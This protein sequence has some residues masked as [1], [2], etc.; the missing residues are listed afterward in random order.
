MQTKEYEIIRKLSKKNRILI[1]LNSLLITSCAILLF[2]I[3]CQ[4]A[5]VKPYIFYTVQ[6]GDTVSSISRISGLSIAEIRQA[7][8]FK[9]DMIYIGDVL[10]LP[11]IS[12]LKN[13]Q[14]LQ[15]LPIITRNEWGA[16][17]AGVCDKATSFK[18]ITVHHTTDNDK[19]VKT[20]IEFL[21]LVQKHHQKTNKWADIGYHFLIGQGGNL[22]EGRNLKFTGAHVRGKNAGNIGIALL[23]DY[24]EHELKPKQ[25]ETLRKL[26]D[27][28]RE[29]YN[30]PKRMIFG[31]GELGE[32]KCP[33]KHTLKFLS[34]YRK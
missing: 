5:E 15:E 28:L 2:L 18:R 6:S 13:G 1:M 8:D 34:N 22:Y 7:N 30:I 19:F 12:K 27:A 3:S 24:N 10:K 20:D 26:I 23:G 25:L 14:L 9:N 32:T 11:G 4:T 33:G 17:K 29:R 31:H 16:N 21:R